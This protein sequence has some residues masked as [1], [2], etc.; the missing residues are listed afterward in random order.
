MGD[1]PSAY[2]LPICSPEG[3]NLQPLYA[4]SLSKLNADLGT[5]LSLIGDF[6]SDSLG[7]RLLISFAIYFLVGL[8]IVAVGVVILGIFFF[9]LEKF[10]TVVFYRLF[11][12]RD[13]PQRT[14]GQFS[15]GAFAFESDESERGD[16]GHQ[17]EG[18]GPT[19]WEI[20]GVKPDSTKEQVRSAYLLRVKEYHPDKVSQLPRE[21]QALANKR[22]KEI[23]GAYAA[24]RVKG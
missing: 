6:L 16:A 12:R 21:F 13:S 14:A 4:E 17:Q 8:L 15:E 1:R 19:P 18:V 3:A 2:V 20:L 9:G 24:L 23:N 10:E 11:R 7:G 22:M 5:A